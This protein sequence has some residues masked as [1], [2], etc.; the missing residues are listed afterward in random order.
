MSFDRKE[1]LDKVYFGIGTVGYGTV[2][3][4]HFAYDDNFKPFEKPDPEGAKQVV[5]DVGKGPLSFEL[6][7]S[8][9]DA[10]LV[11]RAQL[12]QAQL[13]KADIDAQISQ[14]EFAQV[15]SEERRVGKECRCGGEW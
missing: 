15:R 8:S 1:H 7:I 3:P 12:I 6:L 14:L 4:S 5:Q 13:K 10:L 2:A 11:Q 9:G